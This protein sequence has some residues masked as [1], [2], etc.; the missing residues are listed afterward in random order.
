MNKQQIQQVSDQQD[1]SVEDDPLAELARIVAG[2]TIVPRKTPELVAQPVEQATVVTTPEV[3]GHEQ[4]PIPIMVEPGEAATPTVIPLSSADDNGGVE[5]STDLESQLLAELGEGEITAAPS[6]TIPKSVQGFTPVTQLLDTAQQQIATE[7]LHQT[8][9]ANFVAEPA[10]AVTP[11]PEI[12]FE[13]ALEQ[14]LVQPQEVPAETV[15]IDVPAAAIPAGVQVASD[16]NP[17]ML[18][19]ENTDAFEDPLDD[20]DLDAAFDDELPSAINAGIGTSADL[21]SEFSHDLAEQAA[22]TDQTFGENEIQDEMMQALQADLVEPDLAAVEEPIV[23]APQFQFQPAPEFLQ[24]DRQIDDSVREIQSEVAEE[25]DIEDAFSDA[26]A[27]ELSMDLGQVEVEHAAAVQAENVAPSMPQSEISFEEPI[28]PVGEGV[29]STPQGE[30]QVASP[31]RG[32]GGIRMAAMALGLAM[33][34]GGGAV[35]YSYMNGPVEPG[36]PVLVKAD[37]SDIKIKPETPGGKT[38]ANQDQPVYDAVAGTK[39]EG[40]TQDSL[41]AT[42][43]E[44]VDIARSVTLNKPVKS[45]NRLS[46]AETDDKKTTGLAVMQPRKVKTVSVRADGSLVPSIGDPVASL[47]SSL[48]S[49]L[50]APAPDTPVIDETT[51]DGA[52]S[53]G[54]IAVPSANPNLPKI[55]AAVVVPKVQEIVPTIVKTRTLVVPKVEPV[56]TKPA[57]VKTAVVSPAPSGEGYAVQISSQRSFDS[58]EATYQNLK[59]RFASLLGDKAKEIQEAKVEGKGTFY[60]VRILQNSKSAALNFCTRYKSAGGSCF[61]TK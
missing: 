47:P 56:V 18:P 35:A 42:S 30:P 27:D 32:K 40:S 20:F 13:A 53:T 19:V 6:D 28:A 10:Q 52:S 45:D 43:E 44:P 17:N 59:R 22:P 33:L 57:P 21:G 54:K 36:D 12:D 1:N 51:I 41:I 61:V 48:Q 23:P 14:Q 11:E 5:S 26:F 31:T 46:T 25:I 50:V 60:R 34:A 15:P 9:R 58:A 8:Q 7:E 49:A 37:T 2:E 38:I 16:G 3:A 39:P 24:P 4:P 29:Q 55:T